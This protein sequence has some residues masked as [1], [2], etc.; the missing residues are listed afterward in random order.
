MMQTSSPPTPKG[1]WKVI[2]ASSAG[3]VIEWYDFYIFGALA[4]TLAS[5]FYNTGTPI[6]DIIAWL[7]TFA[8]G[9]LVRPFGAI[10]FGR[11]GD[12]VGRKFT[13]LITITIMG[14]CTFLIGLLPTQDVLGA[15]AGIILITMR[16]L[17]GLALGGQYGG[18]ATFVAE[19]APQGKRGFYTSW[20]QTTATFGLLIS[21]GVILITRISL[22][23]ADFNEWGWR[24]PFMASILLVILS[25]WI[26]RALKESPLFQQL[27]DTKAVSKNPLKESFANPY[28]LRWVLIALFGATM[29]QGVVWYT[30]QFYALFYLQKIFN[31]PLIDSNLIVGAALLLSMPFFIFFGSLSDRIGRKKVMLSGMLLAVLTYYPIYGL[32]AAFAPTDPGQHFLFAYIGYNPVILGLLVFIQV[33]YVTMVYGPIAAFLVE[34]FP[35][36]IRYTSM[37][38]PYHIGNGVFGGLVPMIGLI[39]INATGND[40]AG[41]WWPMA[42]AGICLVVGF[43]LIKETNKVDISDASTSISV[44]HEADKRALNK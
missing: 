28:N 22:G 12:L 11:I 9:F 23:E 43:L 3:T 21:L 2:F 29:G 13:Y 14:S 38:L 17:Q 41:L 42:I 19:H 10:V 16:I 25:L 24:L 18:A 1:I 4:T 8:V 39:L 31:T 20:I 26:R 32:M 33:I 30:G 36:K 27:K 7:G 37:S 5:K 6:G 35:T 40:F 15:W 34:L 44:K